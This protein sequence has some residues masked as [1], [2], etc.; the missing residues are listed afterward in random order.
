[1]HDDAK[2]IDM[3]TKTKARTRNSWG[4]IRELPSG[5][6]QASYTDPKTKRAVNAPL[7]YS[8]KKKAEI[9]LAA[10]RTFSEAGTLPTFERQVAE[11]LKTISQ[12]ESLTLREHAKEWR[13]Q[14]ETSSSPR[15][16]YTYERML[17]SSLKN[18][19]DLPLADIT[20]DMVASWVSKNGKATP[21]MTR[22]SYTHLKAL[23]TN[24]VRRGKLSS[25]PCDLERSQLPKKSPWR[26]VYA[27]PQQVAKIIE[28]ASEEWLKAFLAIAFYSGLRRGEILELRK[29]DFHI[30]EYKGRHRI[31]ISVSRSVI[32]PKGSPVVRN[33]L[34]TAGSRR[35]VT[36]Q[37]KG[38]RLVMDY[39]G[40]FTSPN[41]L[42][43]HSSTDPDKHVSQTVLFKKWNKVRKAAGFEGRLHDAR[44]IDLTTVASTGA[45]TREIMDRGG[46]RT[47]Q[48]AMR[49]QRNAGL[50]DEYL[51]RL[52]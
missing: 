45:P 15:T 27:D 42:L 34:K 47:A 41:S 24:A 29:K 14:R 52:S 51:D 25:N 4:R 16:L 38:T 46:H 39:L 5:K 3:A 9:W 18:F 23:L 30:R 43:F 12:G 1:L 19:A 20:P 28:C 40:K 37:D 31:D 49:Y 8:D 6:F 50:T 26:E 11:K 22:N 13:E 36:L 44:A 10:Q 48:V 33:E 32:F 7:T 2:E 35:K 17:E 21:K